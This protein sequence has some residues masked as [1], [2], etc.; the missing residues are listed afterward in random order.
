MK[1]MLDI[2]LIVGLLWCGY[3]W[4]G[5]K[6][7]GLALGDEIDQLK[8]TAARLE[9]DLGKATNSLNEAK[10]DLTGA[11]VEVARLAKDVQDKVDALGAKST[12]AD[13]LRTKLAAAVARIKELEGYKAKAIVAEMPKPAAP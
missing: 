6:Q 1:Y 8:A 11:Q 12:E 13:E 5:E 9:L 3:L 4:N 7:N 10:A 2:L